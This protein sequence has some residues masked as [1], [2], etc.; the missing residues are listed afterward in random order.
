MNN[1]MY[2]TMYLIFGVIGLFMSYA[3]LGNYNQIMEFFPALK[4]SLIVFIGGVCILSGFIFLGISVSFF[5][6]D[7]EKDANSQNQE[8]RKETG[9]LE[10]AN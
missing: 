9:I 2:G 7:N 6:D 8:N 4:E 1:K 5:F 10:N 3:F